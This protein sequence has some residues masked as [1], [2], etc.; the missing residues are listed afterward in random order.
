MERDELT[1]KII[2][3]AM[4]VHKTLGNG[5]QEVIYQ[6]C[7]AIELVNAGLH[8]ERERE[9]TIFYEGINVGTRR[10]DFIVENHLVVELK[11]LINL[12]D[13]HL[14]QAKNY[15]VAYDFARGLLINFGAI[16]LQHKLI[17]N[18]KYNSKLSS[19]TP[20]SV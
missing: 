19:E 4:K 18:P 12:E 14:A 7:L 15:V 10:A 17:F 5:F 8:F 1:Y 6:R 3:C 13:V 20:S 16:S 9:Q 11:A 2:G